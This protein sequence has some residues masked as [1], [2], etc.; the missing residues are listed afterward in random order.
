MDPII[1]VYQIWQ[2]G[3]LSLVA[4]LLREGHSEIKPRVDDTLETVVKASHIRQ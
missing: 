2:E 1:R 3:P 4:T